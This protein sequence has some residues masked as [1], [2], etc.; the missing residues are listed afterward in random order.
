MCA[1]IQRS[2]HMEVGG[3]HPLVPLPTP[4][5]PHP[6]ADA[7]VLLTH[8]NCEVGFRKHLSSMLAQILKAAEKTKVP[9]DVVVPEKK[10]YVAGS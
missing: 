8:A 2:G 10:L 4:E 1:V 7:T 9:G 3:Y 6:R 5:N